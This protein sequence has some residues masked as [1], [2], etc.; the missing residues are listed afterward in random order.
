MPLAYLAPSVS[1]A[2][3]APHANGRAV[4]ARFYAFDIPHTKY[5]VA[6]S[7]VLGRYQ[8]TTDT[9]IIVGDTNWFIALGSKQLERLLIQLNSEPHIQLMMPFIVREELNSK[10][11]QCRGKHGWKERHLFDVCM[12][13]RSLLDT[14][15]A[16]MIMH[17]SENLSAAAKVEVDRATTRDDKIAVIY[18]EVLAVAPAIL[19]THDVLF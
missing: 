9:R 14:P 18:L 3:G 4:F 13:I 2:L 5:L 6:R 17:S 15:P 19:M 10:I 8:V 16:S 7:Q 1:K 12:D 11:N